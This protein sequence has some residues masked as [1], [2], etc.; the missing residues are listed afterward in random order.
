MVPNAPLPD[1]IEAWKIFRLASNENEVFGTYLAS[2]FNKA[3]GSDFSVLDIGTG[4]GKLLQN[5]LF[6]CKSKPTKVTVIE[7][8]QEFLGECQR[9]LSISSLSEDIE[10]VPSK[11]SEVDASKLTGHSFVIAAHVLYLIDWSE[12]R[13]LVEDLT[14]GTTILI[15]ADSDDSIFSKIWRKTA[16]QHYDRLQETL[17][18]LRKHYAHLIKSETPKSSKLI[19]PGY[20]RDDIRDMILSLLSYTDVRDKD[21]ETYDWVQKKVAEH[22]DNGRISCDCQCIELRL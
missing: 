1:Y 14:D 21:S 19:D 4:D 9:N 22:V 17:S 8:D 18:N 6:R 13:P 12:F 16:P 7:P 5:A 20:F 3:A 2:K 10:F 11:L 15:I